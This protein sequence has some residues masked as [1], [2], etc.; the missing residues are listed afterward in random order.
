M[1]LIHDMTEKIRAWGQTIRIHA[2]AE[3]LKCRICGQEYFSRGKYD[4]GI[5]RECE[6]N[7]K[8]IG[9]PLDGEYADEKQN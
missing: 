6:K 1:A 3:M 8:L 5:C 4:I 2:S 9:G 7:A